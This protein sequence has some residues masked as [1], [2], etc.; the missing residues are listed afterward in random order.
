MPY[1][2]V[3][4]LPSTTKKLS[5]HGKSVFRAAFNSAYKQYK[6]DESKAFAVAWAA[7]NKVSDATK[8][9]DEDDLTLTVPAL[10][11]LMEYGREK[12]KTDLDLHKVVEKVAA[13]HLKKGCIESSDLEGIADA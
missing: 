1:A 11:R 3:K 4:E 9:Q 8:D 2:S 12:A 5:K 10:V 6:G 13:K 7:A